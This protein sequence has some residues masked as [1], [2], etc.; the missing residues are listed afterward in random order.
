M[1]F[2]RVSRPLA[3]KCVCLGMAASLVVGSV[4][5]A[6]DIERAIG[7]GAGVLGAILRSQQSQPSQPPASAPVQQDRQDQ[8]TIVHPRNRGT[9]LD[10]THRPV[11]DPAYRPAVD[12]RSPSHNGFA[13]RSERA[14]LRCWTGRRPTR[15]ED[16]SRRRSLS[17]QPRL[18]ATGTLDAMQRLALDAEVQ[19][20]ESDGLE[21]AKLHQAEVLRP[22]RAIC[23]SLATIQASRMAH[24]ARGLRPRSMRSVAT[25]ASPFPTRRSRPM[26]GRRSIRVCTAC[27][28]Q[29]T[30]MLPVDFR[31]PPVLANTAP[32][33]NCAGARRASEQAI[34]GNPRLA[35]LDRQV[36]AAWEQ[37]SSTAAGQAASLAAAKGLAGRTRRLRLRRRVPDCAYDRARHRM[38]RCPT[39]GLQRRFERCGGG[40]SRVR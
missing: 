5:Q 1:I 25:P 37:K 2:R 13:E 40:S 15:S 8:S 10:P 33:F 23:V 18:N 39:R 9:S 22:S 20:L 4:A 12:F 35:A 36:A 11:V 21:R 16:A 38:D 6:G 28:R 27:R 24:G 34:C 31:A 19:R 14:R 7:I 29:V 3:K 30:R 32:S 17:G 26:I